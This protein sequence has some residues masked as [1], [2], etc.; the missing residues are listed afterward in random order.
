MENQERIIRIL[1]DKSVLF[2][3]ILLVI[4]MSITN[5]HFL[6]FRN[7]TNVLV[8]ISI[9]GVVAFAMTYAIICQEF[10]LSVS[11]TF[12]LATIFFIDFSARLGILPAIFIVLVIGAV[13]GFING[14][15]VSKVK[16]NAFVATMGMMVALRGLAL[17]YT[18]GKPIRNND[19]IL[20]T[21]GN[22]DLF[23]IPYLVLVFFF[24][25][26][27]SEF[28]LKKTKFGRNIY[29]TGGN[30]NVAQMAG[31]NVDFYKTIVFVILGIT[32]SF[33]GIMMSF[34]MGAGS[35]LYG[36]DLALSVV[37]AVV[38]GGTSLTGGRG[39]A[40]KTLVGILVVGVLFNALTLLQIQAY[41]QE[42]VKGII[43]IL[44]VSLDTYYSKSGG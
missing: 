9:Y 43:L 40:L 2:I 30:I 37:A 31:I 21:I 20:Y 3:L 6:T 16:M 23:G 42:V 5:S 26:I 14:I 12:A 28:I 19:E 1:R 7:V 10:D 34:R 8:Q 39:S 25:L 13:I 38:I 27:L 22:G 35:A 15:L 29:A 11:S 36:S 32:A 41:Y 18:D 24:F 44:V 33:A 17:F 4:V